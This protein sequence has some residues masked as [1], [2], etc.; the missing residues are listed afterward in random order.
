VTIAEGGPRRVEGVPAFLE[1]AHTRPAD[2]SE[3][4]QLARLLSDRCA[5]LGSRVE[6]AGDRLVFGS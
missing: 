5:A 1:Y 3:T 2:R 6:V 4:E